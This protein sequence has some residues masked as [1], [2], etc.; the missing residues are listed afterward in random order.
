MRIIGK[1]D[2]VGTIREAYVEE[3]DIGSNVTRIATKHGKNLR[4]WLE[5]V[6]REVRQVLGKE[7]RKKTD[8][9]P[10]VEN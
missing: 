1:F 4:Y 2:V 8:V 10:Y 3:L 5:S 7:D 9:S 6:K